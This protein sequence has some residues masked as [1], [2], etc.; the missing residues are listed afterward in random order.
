[1]LDQH[2]FIQGI[3]HITD[4]EGYDH[5]LF[6]AALSAGFVLSQWKKVILLATAFTIGHSITLVLSAFNLLT[7]ASS[8]IEWLIPLTIALTAIFKLL[9]KREEEPL[10]AA[11]FS[12]TMA[13]GLIHGMG[14]S[15]F[16]KMMFSDT[17]SMIKA[18]LFFNLGV[19]VG[20]LLIISCLISLSTLL[21]T[22]LY[23][24]ALLWKRTVALFCL[25]LG[26]WL[27]VERF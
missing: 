12:I 1:M 15:S 20:Q 26:V 10:T 7:F 17:G 19:E 22:R 2:P 4:W 11:V 23:I 16:F 6:L 5:M 21:I 8:T 25:I 9:V 24:P 13:F 27:F 14:F 3:Y 18:L